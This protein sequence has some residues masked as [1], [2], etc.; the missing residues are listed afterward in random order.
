LQ[1][2]EFNGADLRGTD[3]S[4]AH[5]ENANF[6][7]AI[8]ESTNLYGTHLHNTRF[9]SA[10]IKEADLREAVGLTAAQLLYTSRDTSTKLD[11]MLFGELEQISQSFDEP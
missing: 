3:F 9:L 6:G 11:A 10:N 4:G 1:G 7:N 8:L 5:L 2:L